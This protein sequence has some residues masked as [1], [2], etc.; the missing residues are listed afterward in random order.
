VLSATSAAQD[1]GLFEQLYNRVQELVVPNFNSQMNPNP[2]QVL[3]FEMPGLA[4]N[5]AD[6]D[7]AS[8]IG[9][10]YAGSQ[11]D[12]MVARLVNRAT[13]FAGPT[14]IDS[15]R[16]ISNTWRAL[17]YQYI[18]PVVDNP[19]AVAKADEAR[20][21]LNN[22][23][24][25]T[26]Y[27]TRLDAYE[28]TLAQLT[29][30]RDD[31]LLKQPAAICA[32]NLVTW[33]ERLRRR[34]FSLE[35]ARRDVAAA[36]SRLLALQ[37]SD[38]TT[39]FAD[40]LEQFASNE[41]IDVGA[42]TAGQ[43]YYYTS[44]SPSNWWRWWPQNVGSW[45]FS[46]DA[47]ATININITNPNPT[48]AL[49]PS[50]GSATLSGSV[51]TYTALENSGIDRIGISYTDPSIGNSTKIRYISVN[52]IGNDVSAASTAFVKLSITSQ[53][54][55][56]SASSKSSFSQTFLSTTDRSTSNS[57]S[58]FGWW[59]SSGSSYSSSSSSSSST[60]NS[61]SYSSSQSFSSSNSDSSLSFEIARV[62]ISRPWLDVSL[63]SYYPVAI[64]GVAKGAWSDGTAQASPRVLHALKVLPVAFIVARNIVIRNTAWGATY[65][66]TVANS[67]SS[68]TSDSQGS[69]SR[70]SIGP[71]F[72]GSSSSAGS[73]SSTGRDYQERSSF[74]S[75][76]SSS[77]TAGSLTIKG[78]QIIAWACT[79]VPAFPTASEDEV[80]AFEQRQVAK[81]AMRLAATKTATTSTTA[82]ASSPTT[83][84][85][86]SP[87]S[88]SS[89][90]P[91][92][93]TT[94]APTTAKN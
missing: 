60:T 32:K 47:L 23:S 68:T 9:G 50:R 62:S 51:L 1:I 72:T 59:G 81:T 70:V 40:A 48:I 36:E 64:R 37:V 53:Q 44:L 28:S 19:D 71:F 84:S 57:Y 4:I 63:L 69:S 56:A 17:L 49:Q 22:G 85:S 25:S 52:V 58:N 18:V 45:D 29:N 5:R 78:P 43:S 83:A 24:L 55:R 16:T 27:E 61:V 20:V 2:T 35:V 93:G 11:P 54:S 6:Y 38:L 76:S 8:W 73:S 75:E 46:V 88:S 90:S 65:D 31:C 34:W 39:T 89:S 30:A 15:G 41:R 7:E 80:V 13:Y 67:R 21:Q 82:T 86:S 66:A 12:A 77:N 33:N 42:A 3:L 92:S 87:S 79:I 14:F 10:G 91:S 26:V 74:K 94:T